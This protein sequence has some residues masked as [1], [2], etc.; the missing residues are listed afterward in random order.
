[1]LRNNSRSWNR[2]EGVRSPVAVVI[3]IQM[4]IHEGGVAAALVILLRAVI[5]VTAS[6]IWPQIRFVVARV[7]P[8]LTNK[9]GL[10]GLADGRSPDPVG[11]DDEAV[12]M[13]GH[14]SSR[15]WLGGRT[16]PNGGI[17]EIRREEVVEIRAV[18]ASSQDG[19]AVA[20]LARKA[21]VVFVHIQG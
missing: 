15:S 7:F 5:Q 4:A 2:R 13:V 20:G 17:A 18:A 14:E 6:L 11:G 16:K 10:R 8:C 21:V 9:Q 3:P 12:H 1:M 19:D